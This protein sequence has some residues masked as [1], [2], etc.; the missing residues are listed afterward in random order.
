VGAATCWHHDKGDAAAVVVLHPQSGAV[1]GVIG[2]SGL[3]A[4]EEEDLA[5][6]GLQ[7]LGL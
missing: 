3:T 4:Q 7:S 6:L 5:R 2:I 1:L